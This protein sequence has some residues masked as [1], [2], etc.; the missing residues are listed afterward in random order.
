M[1]I[2]L[3]S[4]TAKS[5]PLIDMDVEFPR[6]N[7]RREALSTRFVYVP[8]LT[9]TLRVSN[10]PSATFKT[11]LK[12]DA[13]NGKV[14]RHDFGNRIAG[15]A[16]FIPKGSG[17]EDDGYLAVLAYDPVN[18]TSD[19]VLLDAAHMDAKPVAI[20]RLPQR[21]PQGLHGNWIPNV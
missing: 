12:V 2:D 5:A 11:L 9:D 15:E 8:T 14:S 1:N 10:P 6:V 17:A 21:V 18:Q 3:S 7:D 13:E 19:F 16:I 20:V 4:R